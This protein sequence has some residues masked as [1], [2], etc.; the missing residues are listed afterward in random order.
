MEPASRR[1]D[2]RLNAF[3]A[4]LADRR[5]AG[6]VAAPRYVAGRPAQV[7]RGRAPGLS[8][9]APAGLKTAWPCRTRD[10]H[11]LPVPTGGESGGIG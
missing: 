5:L 10:H 2:P 6:S 9:P 4:D 1:L 3:R 8:R 7:T 11:R